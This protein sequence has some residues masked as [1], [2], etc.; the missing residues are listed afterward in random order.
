MHKVCILHTDCGF[1]GALLDYLH[2]LCTSSSRLQ[3][4]SEAGTIRELI[5]AFELLNGTR[6]GICA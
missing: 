2:Y 4:C 1:D 3:A 6:S 5:Y